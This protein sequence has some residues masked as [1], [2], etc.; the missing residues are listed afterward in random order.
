[1]PS[2][3]LCLPVVGSQLILSVKY[4]LRVVLMHDGF[5]G[6]NHLYS[7]VKHKGVWWKTTENTVIEASTF[8]YLSTQ[9]RNLPSLRSLKWRFWKILQAYIW[10]LDRFC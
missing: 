9:Y 10:V 6:R 4:D 2:E 3:L 5:Y 8:L 1:M 7:Y